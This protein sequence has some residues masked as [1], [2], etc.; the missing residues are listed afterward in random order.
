MPFNSLHFIYFFPT[1][2]F[3]YFAIPARFRWILLLAASYY[4]YM[5]WRVAY[6]G[7][8]VA[9]TLVVYFSAIRI[10]E[11]TDPRW[12][13]F[14]LLVSVVFN[15]GILFAFKYFNF[16]S[17]SLQQL[18]DHWQLGFR[19][20]I[21]DV[22]L[23][24]GISFYSFQVVSYSID[25]YRGDK[26][27]E[28]HLGIFALF[29]CFFP[30]LLA[31]PIARSG[32]LIPQFFEKHD[33]DYVRVTDGLKQ[34]F[35]GLFK[36]VVIADRLAVLVDTVYAE[37]RNYDGFALLLASVFF[38]FQVYC[39]FSGYSD[40]AIGSAKVMGYRLATNFNRPY[41]ARSVPE[42][43][44]RW[45]MSLTT[46]FMDY[47]YLPTVV[48]RRNWGFQVAVVWAT[49]VTFTLSGL[50]HGAYWTFIVFGMI[51][52]VALCL[53]VSTRRPRKRLTSFIPPR[54][55]NH[56]CLIAMLIFVTYV[57]VFFRASTMSDALYIISNMTSGTLREFWG[58]AQAGF[59]PA[60]ANLL[61]QGLILDRYDILLAITLIVFLE[62]VQLVQSKVVISEFLRERPTWQR[63]T[64][65][66]AATVAFLL[67]GSFNNSVQFIYLQF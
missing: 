47:L 27:A 5:S 34:M 57:D 44:R 45:H 11:A 50:W 53:E 14:F 66:Y 33:F 61:I 63:W 48:K 3:L 2:V 9:S 12:K 24:V 28:R 55:Y 54:I 26:T 40:V 30:Q 7:L 29:V 39:D 67:L 8:I 22:L 37:P 19:A 46:W 65:Y 6:A 20:P 32:N 1:V 18:F 38:V 59:S 36:K 10:E 35:W 16:L 21:F 15:L 25:V 64:V 13:K 42:Y 17:T 49:M 60:A 62:L 43:W 56:L 41:A 58:V 51:W 4:F 23:P 52:G 31:G